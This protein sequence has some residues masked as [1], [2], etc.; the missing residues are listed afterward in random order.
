V[1]KVD[2]IRRAKPDYGK[3]DFLKSFPFRDAQA[4]KQVEQS[5]LRLG[6]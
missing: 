3:S 2:D 6:F 4:R 5:L 1:A